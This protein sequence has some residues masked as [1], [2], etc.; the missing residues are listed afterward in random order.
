RLRDLEWRHRSIL[1]VCSLLDWPW[2][3]DSYQRKLD[4][5]E[6]E[7]FFAPIQTFGV[8]PRTLIFLLGELPFLTGLYER[9]RRELT[10]DANLSVDGVKE[11]ILQARERLKATLPRVAKRITPQVLSI[12]F[13]YVRNLSLM[14]RQLTPDLYS[15]IV[16]AQQTAG[17]DFALAVAE[18]AREY[19]H[20]GDPDSDD[21]S[22]QHSAL[23]TQHS[24]LRMGIG[25][26]EVP[27]WGLAPLVSRLPGQ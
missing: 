18:T 25:R 21:P 11:L 17:D 9:G 10:P 5:E 12:Y 22:T 23:S 24:L 16:A 20:A 19:P 14:D 15:L 3:R 27:G 4:V 26:A 6:P 7:P 13:R 1:L 8:D 2:I